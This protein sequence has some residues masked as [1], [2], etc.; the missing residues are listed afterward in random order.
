VSDEFT[1]DM[2]L[3]EAY[4]AAAAGRAEILLEDGRKI[5]RLGLVGDLTVDGAAYE[6][7]PEERSALTAELRQVESQAHLDPR[8]N[9]MIR[10]D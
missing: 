8:T 3:I 1:L 9:P 6:L 10:T 2:E 4:E 7:G 5:S